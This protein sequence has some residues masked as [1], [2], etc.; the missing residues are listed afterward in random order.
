MMAVPRNQEMNEGHKTD[1]NHKGGVPLVRQ[2]TTM[3]HHAQDTNPCGRRSHD[4]TQLVT[5]VSIAGNAH[6]GISGTSFGQ[7][8]NGYT[9]LDGT[10]SEGDG[11]GDIGDNETNTFGCLVSKM[12]K[13]GPNGSR[14]V[15]CLAR[16][17]PVYSFL[18]YN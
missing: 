17:Q 11:S 4:A 1:T 10:S 15:L 9:F 2:Q 18:L 14:M 13:E 12:G 8:D 5:D 6:V 7:G 16:G 3:I